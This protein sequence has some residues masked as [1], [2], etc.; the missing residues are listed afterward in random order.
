MEHENIVAYGDGWYSVRNE[1]GSVETF[2]GVAEPQP[3]RSPYQQ[4]KQNKT[5][6]LRASY[7]ALKQQFALLVVLSFASTAT[8]CLAERVLTVYQ[9]EKIIDRVIQSNPTFDDFSD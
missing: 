2:V 6:P 8:G 1:D 7:R 9:L 4:A 3:C 5:I